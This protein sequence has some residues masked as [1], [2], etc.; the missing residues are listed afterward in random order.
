[1]E[2]IDKA[3][4]KLGT[5]IRTAFGQV[6]IS[7]GTETQKVPV[8]SFSEGNI[9]LGLK[10]VSYYDERKGVHQDP[11]PKLTASFNGKFV[12]VPV[13]GKWWRHFA[14]FTEKI[15]QALEGVEI[16]N[17]NIKDDVSYAKDL[18]SKYRTE[19]E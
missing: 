18:M 1:M 13:S 2:K 3:T 4:S 11:V 15:A 14:D 9:Y 7:E 5:D 19:K 17:S 8:M 10:L 12:E 6:N 16:V